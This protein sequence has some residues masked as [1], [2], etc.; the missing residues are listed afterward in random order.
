MSTSNLADQLNP[1]ESERDFQAQ[2]TRNSADPEHRFPELTCTVPLL[3][4]N[5]A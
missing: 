5:P 1:V 4:G 2:F 3:D